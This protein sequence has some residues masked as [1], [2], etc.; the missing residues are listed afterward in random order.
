M[1]MQGVAPAI[2]VVHFA[3]YNAF[4]RLHLLLNKWSVRRV[5]FVFFRPHRFYLDALLKRSSTFFQLMTFQIA[6]T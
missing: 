6:L 5:V 3:A 4:S 1:F 2:Q